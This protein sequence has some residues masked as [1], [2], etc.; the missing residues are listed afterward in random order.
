MAKRDPKAV[1]LVDYTAAK[2]FHTR[3]VDKLEKAKAIVSTGDAKVVTAAARLAYAQAKCK[4]LGVEV[5]S[6]PKA[7]EAATPDANPLF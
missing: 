2:K 4:Q 6:E 5:D 7:I 1:A 3:E